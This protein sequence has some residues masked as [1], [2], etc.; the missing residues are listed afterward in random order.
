M[1]I[2]Y[3]YLFIKSII[4]SFLMGKGGLLLLIVREVFCING[5]NFREMVHKP[6]KK[7]FVNAF[8]LKDKPDCIIL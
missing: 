8:V 2:L 5:H 6:K 1:F 7:C 3:I 4:H